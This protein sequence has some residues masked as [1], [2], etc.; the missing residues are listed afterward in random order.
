MRVSPLQ[1]GAFA[2]PLGSEAGQH[3]FD[4]AA[5]VREEQEDVRLYTPQ[6]GRIE[7]RA[8]I[9]NRNVTLRSPTSRS[10]R[11]VRVGC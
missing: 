10:S 4:P 5:R 11:Q 1:T 7:L 2:G 9:C 8:P 3:R 6:Y